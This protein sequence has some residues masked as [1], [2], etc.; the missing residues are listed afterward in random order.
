MKTY[1]L[2]SKRA[3]FLRDGGAFHYFNYELS[4]AMCVTHSQIWMEFAIYIDGVIEFKSK[5]LLTVISKVRDYYYP[6][7]YK[8]EGK[9]TVIPRGYE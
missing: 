1:L 6:L 5:N 2:N 4:K 7:G 9:H 3:D 8:F